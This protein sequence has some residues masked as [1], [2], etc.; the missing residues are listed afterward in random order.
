MKRLALAAAAAIAACSFALPAAADQAG[1]LYAYGLNESAYGDFVFSVDAYKPLGHGTSRLRP[2]VDVFAT[3]DTKTGSY[4]DIPHIYSDNYAGAAL[5]LQYTDG[6]GLRLF[7]Q[8]GATSRIG[9]VASV[10]S[11]GDFR[12]GAQYYRE[13]AGPSHGRRDYGNFFGSATYYSRYQDAY[14]YNQL[15]LGRNVG[16]LT[17]PTELYVRTTLTLDTHPY[18]YGNSAEVIGGVRFHPFGRRGPAIEFDGIVGS[19]LRKDLLPPG[20]AQHYTDFRPTVSYG[21]NL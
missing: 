4:L 13:W 15:E 21:V 11:G 1:Y 20:T 6:K 8:G 9:S 10:R 17:H 2:Y 5:G 16:A 12:G 3:K 7:A 18:F 19:Y 14:A